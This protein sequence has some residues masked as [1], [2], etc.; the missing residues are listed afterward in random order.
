MLLLETGAKPYH[1]PTRAPD[2]S[3]VSGA[4][5]TS[6]AAFTLALS[7]ARANNSCNV[8]SLV[9]DAAIISRETY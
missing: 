9:G 3:D 1:T 5:D 4:G 8:G 6:I 7:F 2:V